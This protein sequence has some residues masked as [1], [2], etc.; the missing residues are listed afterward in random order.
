MQNSTDDP[1]ITAPQDRSTPLV[2][3]SHDHAQQPS[4]PPSSGR[5]PDALTAQ[6]SSMVSKMVSLT[7]D[8]NEETVFAAEIHMGL[9]PAAPLGLRP[10]ILLHDGPSKENRL[11]GAAAWRTPFSPNSLA[12]SIRSALL[13]PPFVPGGSSPGF[14]E[15]IMTV[16]HRSP[17]GATRGLSCTA[18][19]VAVPYQCQVRPDNDFGFYFSTGLGRNGDVTRENFCWRKVEKHGADDIGS[20]GFDLVQLPAAAGQASVSDGERLATLRWLKKFTRRFSLKFSH[21]GGSD[22][23]VYDDRWRLVVVITALRLWHLHVNGRTSKTMISIG[24]MLRGK[25]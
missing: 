14:I 2:E 8:H 13:L 1:S 6:M 21:V 24:G 4:P 11:L 17:Y 22:M 7:D 23:G 12:F 19:S 15:E 16:R 18:T 20:G 3:E 25:L 9:S 5:V 10:G